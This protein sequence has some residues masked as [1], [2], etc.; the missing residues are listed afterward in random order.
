M[1]AAEKDEIPQA[2]VLDNKPLAEVI[3]ELQWELDTTGPGLEIDPGFRILL[4][5]FY[6]RAIKEF[7][8]VENLPHANIPEEM[9]PRQVR[10]RFRV[11][12][13][14]WPLTQI[15][16]GILSVNDTEGY[17]WD[18]FQPR[19]QSAVAALF[20]SY[21]SEVKA[22]KPS[23]VVLRYLN[24]VPFDAEKS[25]TTVLQ[26]LEKH[27]HT[28]INI[29]PKLFESPEIASSPVGMNL[30]LSYLLPA[31]PGAGTIS[32]ATGLKEG[33][34]TILWDT[35][36]VS[37]GEDAP[38]EIRALDDWLTKAHDIAEKWFLTL[39]RGDLYESFKE[40][41]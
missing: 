17:T 12:K 15:G 34:Q 30:N 16:P 39:T 38:T 19:I 36:I 40:K 10:H 22:L 32:F 3:F 21:P 35:Q 13:N 31:L 1:P 6:D 27:L 8:D 4:G 41:R 37:R 7:P 23:Q 14:Q 25:D 18:S 11:G 29:E 33:K 9:T 28:S 26:F 5:R 24:G 2:Q 20:G